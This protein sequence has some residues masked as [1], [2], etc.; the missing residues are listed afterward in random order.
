MIAFAFFVAVAFGPQSAAM[1]K[2]KKTLKAAVDKA[3]GQGAGFRAISA[4]PEL[5]D[6][7]AVASVEL[8]KGQEFKTVQQSLE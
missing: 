5:K 7:H 4:T 1:S 8:L 6:G 3:I 2:A